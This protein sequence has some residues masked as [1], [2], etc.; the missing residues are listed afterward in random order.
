[1]TLAQSSPAGGSAKFENQVRFYDVSI[2]EADPNIT[3]N[4]ASV[5]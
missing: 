4:S 2:I 3:K 1:M 5:N